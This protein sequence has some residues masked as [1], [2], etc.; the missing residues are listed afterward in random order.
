VV[1]VSVSG[2]VMNDDAFEGCR[3]MLCRWSGRPAKSR[4]VSSSC[5]SVDARV[6]ASGRAGD[7]MLSKVMWM[8]GLGLLGMGGI[9]G[10]VLCLNVAEVDALSYAG[11]STARRPLLRTGE[12]R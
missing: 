4:Y 6:A 3:E 11:D 5:W 8:S 1:S 9:G 10:A 7:V 12:H 2:A